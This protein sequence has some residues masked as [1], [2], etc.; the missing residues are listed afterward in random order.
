MEE[1]HITYT[2]V[3]YDYKIKERINST[4]TTNFLKMLL[5]SDKKRSE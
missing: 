4:W 3:D 5:G 1:G 2:L